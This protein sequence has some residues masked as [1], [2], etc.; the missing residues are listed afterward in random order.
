[1]LASELNREN[2]QDEFTLGL[3]SGLDA[4]LGLPMIDVIEA[5]PFPEHIKQ[6]LITPDK[7]PKNILSLVKQLE[8]DLDGVASQT[9]FIAKLSRCYWEGINWADELIEF[10]ES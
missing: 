10:V 2:V 9:S 1:L 8:Q 5:I 3:F 4:V 6:A 7:G